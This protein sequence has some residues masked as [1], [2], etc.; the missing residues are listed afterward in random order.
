MEKKESQPTQKAVRSLVVSLAPPEEIYQEFLKQNERSPYLLRFY[1]GIKGE[2]EEKRYTL[3]GGKINPDENFQE[4]IQREI[5]EESGLKFL[6][7]PQQTI[8][9]QW[10]YSSPK[11]GEREVIL[12]YNPVLPP[13]YQ[14]LIG[15]PKITAI[16]I[17]NLDQLEKLFEDGWLEGIPIESH[18]AIKSREKDSITISDEETLVKDRSMRKLLAWMEHIEIYLRKRLGEII[19]RNGQ[20]ISEEE[21][22]NEYEKILG[23]F[24]REGVKAAIKKKESEEPRRHELIEALDSGYLGKDILYFLPQLIEYGLG[25]PGLEQA[26]EGVKIFIRFLRDVFTNFL[27]QQGLKEEEYKTFISNENIP[28]ERKLTLINTLDQLFREKLKEV[29]NVEDSDLET[30]MI[31]IQNFFRDL[32]NEIKVADP[33]LTHGLYQDFTLT[34]EVNNANFGYLL[35]LFL[36]Y[37]TKTNNHEAERL[38][39]FEAGRH[40]V[41]LMKGLT[42][43][44]HYKSEL[45]KIRN[46]RLQSAINNFFGPI[47]DEQIIQLD[48]NNKMRVRIRQRGNQEYIVDEKPIKSFTSYLRKTFEERSTHI[49]DFYTISVTFLKNN[50][51]LVNPEILIENLTKFLNKHFPKSNLSIRDKRSYGTKLYLSFNEAQHIIHG[52][53]KG[54][55]G[56]KFVRTKLLF[57]LDDEKLEL[58]IYPLY[59]TGGMSNRFWGWL[60]TRI[61]DK[62]YVV[63]RLLAQEKGFPSLYDLLFPPDL[64]PHHYSHKLSSNYHL[65]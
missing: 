47:V 14:P 58:I 19:F 54:S 48:E 2:G 4:A 45:T 10:Q 51:E 36:G 60:E 18:L 62:N 25:W 52:K 23:K 57:I 29:F 61:D 1:L 44:K 37:D 3:L 30:V 11:S 5:A 41:L 6:G 12:T 8:I 7:I 59:S 21:F 15:D 22:K 33:N 9:G 65:H 31:Y 20:P 38:I 64:Y 32:S 43:I 56:S 40:L 53:R 16:K 13:S 24:M 26:T 28:L 34:N 39:R 17:L 50:Q 49:Y 46:G 42:G 27:Q 55:E 35:S 63:R